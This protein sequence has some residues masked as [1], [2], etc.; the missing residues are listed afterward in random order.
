[1][2]T[3]PEAFMRVQTEIRAIKAAELLAINLDIPH[4][5]RSGMVAAERIAP[6]LPVMAELPEFDVRL[7]ERLSLYAMA[8]LH[9]HEQAN[10]AGVVVP[11]LV[12]LLEEATPLRERMLVSAELLVLFGLVQAARVAA[13]R[14]GL[15]HADTAEDLLALGRL[16]D[17]LW[18]SVHDKVPITREMID[19]AIILSAELQ[20]ALGVRQA[21]PDPLTEPT[22]RRFVR[23]QAFTL[24]ARAYKE[25]QRGVDFLRWYEDDAHRIVPSLYPRRSRKSGAGTDAAE[26]LTATPIVP[27]PVPVPEPVADV[28]VA[29]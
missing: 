12:A 13:I 2:L 21:E 22:D 10:E 16:F 24:F 11:P 15:G 8:L 20:R 23:A 1:V 29:R 5:A 26:D 27:V 14:S 3:S 19:R 17:E 4:A 18:A 25:A 28:P 6:L 9:T 7:V